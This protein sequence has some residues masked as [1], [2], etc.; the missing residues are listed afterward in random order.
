M[1]IFENVRRPQP[2]SLRIFHI[3]HRGARQGEEKNKFE[4]TLHTCNT[5]NPVWQLLCFAAGVPVSP[6]VLVILGLYRYYRYNFSDISVLRKNA[7][8]TGTA[9]RLASAC[10]P[11]M[12]QWGISGSEASC[13]PL[14]VPKGKIC[15]G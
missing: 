10:K 4:L 3:S 15:T 14:F 12:P 9:W 7:E 1:W 11:T 6:I 8:I 2:I 13:V 5:G